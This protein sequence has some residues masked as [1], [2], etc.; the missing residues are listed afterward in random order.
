MNVITGRL[1]GPPTAQPC[2][3]ALGNFDGVH[4]GHQAVIGRAVSAARA[5]GV[6]AAA[7]TFEPHPRRYFAPET[8]GFRLTL[9]PLKQR[10][11][12]A[13]GLDSLFVCRFDQELAELSAEA[14]ARD[15]LSARVGARRV[16]V[17]EDFRFGRGR[18]GDT[19]ALARLGETFDF[20]VETVAPQSDGRE[21]AFS[22]SAARQ[23]LRD[24]R[25]RDAAEILGDWHRIE[26]V[27]EL[28]DQRGRTLGYPTANLTLGDALTPAFGVYATRAAVLDGPWR[29]E[30]DAVSSLGV[31][32]QFDKSEPNFE[33]HFFDFSGDLYGATISVSL[34]AYLRP[35]ARFESVAALV[36]QMDRDS[37]EA[38][39]ALIRA[40]TNR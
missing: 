1:I 12:A 35:E 28:G 7:V 25:P 29:G 32:P 19:A 36:A 22:S 13:L 4:R 33:T 34:I 14:F 24:G 9:E 8:P 27:V 11:L 26:G 37:A 18:A 23:A 31:R 10:R 20:K 40:A 15:V 39:A 16:V 38:R 2:V 21:A 6:A 17:G 3:A 30:Y 5:L